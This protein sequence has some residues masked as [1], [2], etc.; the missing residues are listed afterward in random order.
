MVISSKKFTF[1]SYLC[2]FSAIRDMVFCFIINLKKMASNNNHTVSQ[3]KKVYS[4]TNQ[5]KWVIIYLVLI[6]KTYLF[7]IQC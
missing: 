2:M 4:L 5:R 7:I 1:Q 3:H 6:I